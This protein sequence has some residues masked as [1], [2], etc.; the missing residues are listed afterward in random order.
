M[1]WMAK[2][3]QVQLMLAL[4]KRPP[5][6]VDPQLDAT[7]QPATTGEND[8]AN[9]PSAA[10]TTRDAA[11]A[12]SMGHVSTQTD[13]SPSTPRVEASVQAEP[14]ETATSDST[15]L[16]TLKETVIESNQL[17][18]QNV[19]YNCSRQLVSLLTERSCNVPRSFHTVWK[20]KYTLTLCCSIWSW[21][22]FSLVSFTLTRLFLICMRVLNIKES[23]P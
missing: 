18:E 10:T 13:S 8:Y 21:L 6:P 2:T 20:N 7:A 15:P 22:R 12:V 11:E 3:P 19:F 17:P 5:T 1:Q 23:F 14:I 16:I 4:R 9:L